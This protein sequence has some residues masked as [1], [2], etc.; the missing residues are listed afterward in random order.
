MACWL[1]IKQKKLLEQEMEQSIQGT[2]S[3]VSSI[4]MPHSV[5]QKKIGDLLDVNNLDL[6]GLA[7]FFQLLNQQIELILPV[8]ESASQVNNDIT[9]ENITSVDFPR[10]NDEKIDRLL[11][12]RQLSSKV[13]DWSWLN[14]VMQENGYTQSNTGIE[15]V[16]DGTQNKQISLA[17]LKKPFQAIE[18]DL[19]KKNENISQ[20]VNELLEQTKEDHNFDISDKKNINENAFKR[21]ATNHVVNS[22]VTDQKTM[23]MLSGDTQE[24]LKGTLKENKIINGKNVS[25]VESN[26]FLT[27]NQGNVKVS[28]GEKISSEEMI[29]QV[30]K[31]IKEN[32]N[33]DGG[34]VR[35]TLNPPSLGTLEM[36]V[37]VRNNKVEVIIVAN[38]KDVQQT[39]NTNIDHLKSTLQNQG[40]TID[41]CDVLMQSNH[42]EYPQNSSQQT[43]YRE[44]SE[45]KNNS[46]EETHKE[47]LKSIKPVSPQ[48]VHVSSL[49][50]NNISIFA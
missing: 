25:D 13:K 50:P 41:R 39:L 9:E 33:A 3:L 31:E 5:Q 18:K 34:R 2:T 15:S 19:L 29:H 17:D 48:L 20:T 10:K 24:K 12:Q 35:I 42:E 38:N 47:T 40:L 26:Y 16:P 43:F 44:G 36:D 30:A 37:A 45:K 4:A 21:T 11:T 7:S 27:V 46:L 49:D 22:A 6:N 32:F 8:T 23:N 14:K 28:S 1:Q